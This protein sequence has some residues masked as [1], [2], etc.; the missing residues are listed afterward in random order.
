MSDQIQLVAAIRRGSGPQCAPLF[1]KNRLGDERADAPPSARTQAALR[2]IA[3]NPPNC[4][5]LNN[6]PGMG[7]QHEVSESLS[8]TTPANLT[9]WRPFRQTIL[10]P[11][12]K[13]L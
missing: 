12:N 5:R 3:D 6:N 9:K 8:A 10:S 1:V 11:V 4:Q 7:R 2:E 13:T